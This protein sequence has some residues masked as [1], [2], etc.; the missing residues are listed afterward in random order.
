MLQC[1]SEL[2]QCLQLLYHKM[3]SINLRLGCQV[4]V[5]F[6]IAIHSSNFRE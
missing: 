1:C 6:S 4:V 2:P 3:M 5:G